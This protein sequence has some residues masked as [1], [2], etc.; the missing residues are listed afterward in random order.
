M[1]VVKEVFQ[2]DK[3]TQFLIKFLLFFNTVPFQLNIHRPTMFTVTGVNLVSTV[4]VVAIERGNH[5]AL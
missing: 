5:G 2:V 4:Y 3:E 1:R